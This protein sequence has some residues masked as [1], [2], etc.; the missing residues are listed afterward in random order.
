MRVHYLHEDPDGAPGVSTEP[1]PPAA[2]LRSPAQLTDP[3]GRQ[4]TLLLSDCAGPMW[5]SGV[6]HRLLHR[7]AAAMPVAV[8]QPLPQRMWRST[9]LPARP[10]LLRRPEQQ[11]GRLEF[12]SP[13]GRP[14]HTVPV[15]VLA[16]HH[17]SMGAWA[18]LLSGTG[19]LTQR[20]AAAWV[21]PGQGPAP[22][23][24]GR[25]AVVSAPERVRVFRRHA[26]P[27][28][29]RLAQWLTTTPLELP[30]MQHLQRAMLPDSGPDALAEV[31]LGGLLTRVEREPEGGLAYAF[32]EGSGTSC[33]TGSIPGTPTVP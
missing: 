10:G 3:T 21:G 20:A 29:V 2:P 15:P 22:A 31:L 26:S 24:P 4:L 8:V 18:R 30:V 33:T 27:T 25:S 7:W 23:R 14:P 9:H 16:L 32:R 19:Q 28:A 13:E 5:R 6:L 1:S 11:T 17:L 12:V